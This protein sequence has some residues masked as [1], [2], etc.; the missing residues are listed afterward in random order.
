MDKAFNEIVTTLE[1]GL[2]TVEQ[3]IHQ[4]S[5][6][7]RLVVAVFDECSA[8][9]DALFPFGGEPTEVYEA[10]LKDASDRVLEIAVNLQY[11]YGLD[12]ADML[13]AL[14]AARQDIQNNKN[15]CD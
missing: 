4:A 1:Q 9:I 10:R 2:A 14:A 6:D 8:Q 13:F 5:C 11:E 15:I 7:E 12:D 3:R